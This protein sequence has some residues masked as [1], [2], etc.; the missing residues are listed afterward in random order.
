MPLFFG[1]VER[2]VIVPPMYWVFV[3]VMV[4]LVR[5]VLPLTAS[6]PTVACLRSSTKVHSPAL[7]SSANL[8]PVL[9]TSF[10]LPTPEP[11]VVLWYE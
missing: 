11:E 10:A 5:G 1:G 8:F 9:S 4:F 2:E 3:F 6:S 7:K